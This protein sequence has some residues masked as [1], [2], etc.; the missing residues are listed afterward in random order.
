MQTTL[1]K[2]LLAKIHGAQVT[3][4]NLAYE[5]SITIPEDIIERSGMLPHEAVCVWNVTTGSRFETYILR[6]LRGSQEFHVNGAA[7]HLVSVG[8]R[9]IIAAFTMMPYEQAL[10]HSPTV[11][12]MGADNAIADVRDERPKRVVAL[13]NAA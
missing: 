6:G 1:R 8:D 10:T 12:F 13:G 3:E 5:G 2:M 9:L 7:A 4:A 11:V